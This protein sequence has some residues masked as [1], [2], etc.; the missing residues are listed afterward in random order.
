MLRRSAVVLFFLG[1]AMW[2]PIVPAHARSRVT[3]PAGWP[4]FLSIPRLRLKAPVEAVA[5]NRPTDYH[6]PYRWEDVAWYNRGPRPG[7]TGRAT[8][9]GHL[10]SY[11]CPAIFY[12]LRYLRRGDTVQVAYRTGQLLTF[13]VQWVN[14][15]WNN[16]LPLK[17]L[18]GTTQERGLSL[19]TCSGTFHRDGSGYDH[20][21]VVYARL[22]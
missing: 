12:H 9:F 13:Q 5:F 11:C 8:M 17:Y 16:K 20:K 7:D 15:F 14:N 6:A 22:V 21:L 1:L 10:D 4:K 19:I 3:V 18:F 2:I